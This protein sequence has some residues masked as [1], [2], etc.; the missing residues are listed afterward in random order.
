MYR[1]AEHTSLFIR[2]VLWESIN[3]ISTWLWQCRRLSRMLTGAFNKPREADS[4]LYTEVREETSGN[5]GQD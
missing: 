2:K 3:H 4:L 5:D 1:A